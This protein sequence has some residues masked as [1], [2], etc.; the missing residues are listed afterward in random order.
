M[1]RSRE[2]ADGTDA[3]SSEL[4]DRAD[5]KKLFHQLLFYRIVIAINKRVVQPHPPQSVRIH[6]G[7]AKAVCL[8]AA[9]LH[10]GFGNGPENHRHAKFL[11]RGR[12][13]GAQCK[14]QEMNNQAIH[15]GICEFF[16]CLR[17]LRLILNQIPAVDQLNIE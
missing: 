3:K 9:A 5:H 16:D 6:V 15:S 1:Y 2:R 8:K 13:T 4:T 14:C 11:R 17:S 7:R 12:R 10:R